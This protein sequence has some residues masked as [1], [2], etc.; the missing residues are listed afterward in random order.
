[1]DEFVLLRADAVVGGV[2][3]MRKAVD[4]VSCL[5]AII[6]LAFGLSGCVISPLESGLV[7]D[8]IAQRVTSGAPSMAQWCK[9][10]TANELRSQSRFSAWSQLCAPI[11]EPEPTP[12]MGPG[13]KQ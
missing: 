13:R 6:V 1:M 9:G 3:V 10:V 12:D 5:A 7:R 11:R 4:S 8:L 2:V